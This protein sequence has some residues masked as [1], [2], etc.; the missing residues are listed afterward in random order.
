M[1]RFKS[2][3]AVKIDE[4][5]VRVYTSTETDSHFELI[6]ANNIQDGMSGKS[7]SER[8]VSVEYVPGEGANLIAPVSNGWEGW[9]FT[10][11]TDRPDWWTDMHTRDAI[12]Q[13]RE[14]VCAH[15]NGVNYRPVNEAACESKLRPRSAG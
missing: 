9:T 1:C 11:D 13:L 3:V 12:R 15:I 14:A 4:C 5:R 8:H 7:L 2:G 10:F 6:E